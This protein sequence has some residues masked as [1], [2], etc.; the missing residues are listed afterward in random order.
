MPPLAVKITSDD[1]MWS[2]TY[3]CHS[4]DHNIFVILATGDVY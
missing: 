2:I 3:D 4:D 1:T